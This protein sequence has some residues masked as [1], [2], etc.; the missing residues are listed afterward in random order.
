MSV[1]HKLQ[2]VLRGRGLLVLAVT[3][4]LVWTN[5]RDVGWSAALGDAKP[6]PETDPLTTA[7][8]YRGWP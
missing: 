6:P 8:F 5:L 2:A 7:M 1:L 3:L 4:L